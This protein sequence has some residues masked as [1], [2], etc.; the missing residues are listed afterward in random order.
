M[1]S[2]RLLHFLVGRIL[3][4]EI[5]LLEPCALGKSDRTSEH[6]E[7]F[8]T[9]GVTS[10]SSSP[11][12]P[13]RGTQSAHPVAVA[14]AVLHLC[15]SY[16]LYMFALACVCWLWPG[17]TDRATSQGEFKKVRMVL[18]AVLLVQS[19]AE[20]A[21]WSNGKVPSWMLVPIM[22]TNTCGMLD[23]IWRYP[24]LHN[25]DSAFTCKQILVA[26]LRVNMYIVGWNGLRRDFGW[27]LLW[28]LAAVL[29]LPCLYVFALPLADSR[30]QHMKNSAVNEDILLRL[31]RL[32]SN[33]VARRQ[34]R[35]ELM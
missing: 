18:H 5:W 15:S 13:D 22:I 6:A 25:I 34:F 24:I 32:V 23:A 7:P 16:L 26:I 21:V 11:W 35:T 1:V 17:F 31:W 9:G 30:C 2:A 20:I 33:P 19:V 8:A 12:R 3:V 10:F 28:L 27:F 29:T 14:M 4:L